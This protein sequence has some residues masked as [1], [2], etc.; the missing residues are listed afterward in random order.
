MRRISRL[1][2]GLL[3]V[4]A[5]QALFAADSFLPENSRFTGAEAWV[6]MRDGKQLAADVYVPKA[7]REWP[8]SNDSHSDAL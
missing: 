2:F 4:A 3:L 7:S 1:A 8:T 5:A 6:P